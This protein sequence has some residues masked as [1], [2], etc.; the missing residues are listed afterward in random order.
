MVNLNEHGK[1]DISE[2][3]IQISALLP[4]LDPVGILAIG[5]NYKKHAAETGSPIP[6][7]PGLPQPQVL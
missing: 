2:T 6:K 4:P 3:V 7:H 1:L 5:L